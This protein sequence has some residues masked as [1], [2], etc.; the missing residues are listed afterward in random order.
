MV[1]WSLVHGITVIHDED[2]VDLPLLFHLLDVE[3]FAVLD[4]VAA[5]CNISEIIRGVIFPDPIEIVTL[6]DFS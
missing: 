4:S 5:P 2:N 3:I 1:G 6:T